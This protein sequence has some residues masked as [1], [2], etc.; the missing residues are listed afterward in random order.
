M[1]GSQVLRPESGTF[2]DRL[3]S[4]TRARSWSLSVL[5]HYA[6]LWPVLNSAM[7]FEFRGAVNPDNAWIVG[8]LLSTVAK[9]TKPGFVEELM[10][11]L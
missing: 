8:A 5:S 7:N 9:T 1:G 11:G 6:V 10:T 4:S 2:C 3:V